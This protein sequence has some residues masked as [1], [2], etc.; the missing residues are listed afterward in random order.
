MGRRKTCRYI[1][2][3]FC[4]G[5]PRGCPIVGRSSKID[6][7]VSRYESRPTQTQETDNYPGGLGHKERRS[8][9]PTNDSVLCPGRDFRKEQRS[10]FPTN[11]CVFFIYR[12][13]GYGSSKMPDLRIIAHLQRRLGY[14]SP[15][16]FEL[17]AES[18]P[19]G[20]DNWQLGRF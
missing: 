10:L 4:R 6:S 9:F 19:S 20:S 14:V 2:W 17:S 13:A 18:E 16:C 1:G 12:P 11:D 15:S 7:A 8:P 5:N 3:V